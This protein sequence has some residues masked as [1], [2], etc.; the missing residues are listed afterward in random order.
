MKSN[1][2]KNTSLHIQESNTTEEIKDKLQGTVDK[3]G[4]LALTEV[5]KKARYSG[6]DI[7]KEDVAYAK[8]AA[9]L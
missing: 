5:Y 3:N 7:T 1:I 9:K 6:K 4:I 2:K 8:D